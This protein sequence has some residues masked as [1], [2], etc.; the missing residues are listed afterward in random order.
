MADQCTGSVKIDLQWVLKE[1]LADSREF[2]HAG[3][4]RFDKSWAD[5]TGVDAND[6]LWFST[7]S[8]AATTNLDLDLAGGLNFS[9]FGTNV[10]ISF[11]KVKLIVVWVKSTTTGDKL[12]V[13]PNAS[14]TPL[15]NHILTPWNN[16][17][18]S[19]NVVGADSF[20]MLPSMKDGFAVTAGTGDLLRIRN[21]GAGAVTYEILIVGTSA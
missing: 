8:L 7:G 10:G 20:L 14:G 5:G 11:A 18:E 1:V 16:E 9:L 2:K 13:G 19:V 17:E 4:Q 12:L 3:A 21:P 15:S 6:K